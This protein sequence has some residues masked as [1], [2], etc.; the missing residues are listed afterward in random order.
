[1]MPI[2]ESE[3]ILPTLMLLER[4][5][6]GLN[7]SQLIEQLT[8]TLHPTGDDM[9]ILSGRNDTRFSQKVRNLKSHDTLRGL[10]TS[11]T[12]RNQPSRIT[13]EGRTLYATHKDSLDV[14]TGFSL[15]D[16]EPAL[17]QIATNEPIEVLDPSL[18]RAN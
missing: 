9:R 11:A 8:G 13:E 17:R 14:L 2:S 15:D 6:E 10:A 12:G 5:S 3:L 4:S 7:T 16:S 18:A 1:M